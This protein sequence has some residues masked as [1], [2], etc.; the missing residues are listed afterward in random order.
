MPRRENGFITSLMYIILVFLVVGLGVLLFLNVMANRELAQKRAEEIA[1]SMIPATPVPTPEAA[2]SPTPARNTEDILLSFAGDVVGQMG[3]T[4]QARY[5][6]ESDDDS[7]DGEE[8]APVYAYDYTEVLA[9]VAASLDEADLASCTLGSVL[10][11]AEEYD[12][13]IMPAVFAE[14]LADVGFDMVNTA[15]EQA[16]GHGLEGVSATASAIEENGMVNLGTA[17]DAARFAEN[18]GVYTKVI[19]GVT[20]AFMSYTAGT[21]GN[22]AAEYPYAVNILTTDYMSGQS[23]VDYDRLGA[24][25]TRAKDMG[26]NVIVCYI[27]WWPNANYYT[28]VRDDEKAVVDYLC[29]N[30]ADIIIGGGVKVPQPIELRKIATENGYKN[31]VVAY[32]LGSLVS[33]LNDSYTN[34]SAVLDVQLKRDVDNGEIWISHVSYRPMFMLDTD[35]YSDVSEAPYKYRLYD[36]YSTLAR[37]DAVNEGAD[38]ADPES[39]AADCITYEVYNAMRDGAANLQNILGA[40]FDEANGGVDVPAWSETVQ[41]R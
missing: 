6:I 33:C 18:G 35:D 12:S 15:T 3:L 21:G 14:T 2:P 25:L 10:M 34:L 30:G 40:D 28:D 7:E 9:Q 13:Y 24:D 26:A 39:L 31:C 20:F 17:A 36:L 41:M 22:S 23:A 37:Y 5:E 16:L 4:S 11:D 38:D 29:Q 27:S 32:S 1:A 19:N 8:A